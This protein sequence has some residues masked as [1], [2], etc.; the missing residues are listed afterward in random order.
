[1]FQHLK[2][3]GTNFLFPRPKHS[4]YHF[5]IWVLFLHLGRKTIY[6]FKKLKSPMYH[7]SLF[8]VAWLICFLKMKDR[9]NLYS[10]TRLIRTPRGH[11]MTSVCIIW[12]SVLS[13]I[14]RNCYKRLSLDQGSTVLVFYT[15]SD[16]KKC[17]LCLVL[18]V[19]R[20]PTL[21]LSIYWTQV[22]T[23]AYPL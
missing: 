10:G 23:H 11:A 3:I 8:L 14:K 4:C 20:P 16:T 21:P 2:H 9:T 15:V 7:Y 1:M 6:F 5:G 22:S 18:V 17:A 12:V 13:G 19:N